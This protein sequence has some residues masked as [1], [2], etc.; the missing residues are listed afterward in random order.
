MMRAS[1]PYFGEDFALYQQRIPGAL[2]FLGVANEE[3]GIA[4]YNH[5]PDYDIDERAIGIGT[6]AMANVLISY[7][8]DH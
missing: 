5:S 6:V 4:A 8:E 3:K 2:F 1:A 7:L